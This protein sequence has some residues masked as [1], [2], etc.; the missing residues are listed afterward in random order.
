MWRA[1][2]DELVTGQEALANLDLGSL[3]SVCIQA[4][5]EED[6]VETIRLVGQAPPQGLGPVGSHGLAVL[7]KPTDDDASRTA[8]VVLQTWE[9]EAAF[10]VVDRVHG[11]MDQFGIDE[12]SNDDL[13]GVGRII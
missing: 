3:L 6:T 7:V 8:E 9:R 1:L 12:V 4:V 5:N 10:D 11:L 13:T 2:D